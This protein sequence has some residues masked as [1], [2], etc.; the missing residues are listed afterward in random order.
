MH[1]QN[2]NVKTAAPESSRKIGVGG[3]AYTLNQMTDLF[4]YV[5]ENARHQKQP[6]FFVPPAGGDLMVARSDELNET[7]L[8]WMLEG[9]PLAISIP[10]NNFLAV[11]TGITA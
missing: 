10:E 11:L 7:I 5:L 8:I 4:V 1:T 9:W 2:V 6:G 3:Q